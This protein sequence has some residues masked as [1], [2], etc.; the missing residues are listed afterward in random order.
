LS[1]VLITGLIGVEDKLQHSTGKPKE[2]IAKAMG[3][4]PY[5]EVDNKLE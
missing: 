5:Y 2:T 1:E 3:S 4:Y